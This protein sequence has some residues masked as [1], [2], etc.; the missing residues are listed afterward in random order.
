MT[1]TWRNLEAVSNRCAPFSTLGFHL[2]IVSKSRTRSCH[3]SFVYLEDLLDNSNGL[4]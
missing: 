4:G 3:F 1:E 2:E